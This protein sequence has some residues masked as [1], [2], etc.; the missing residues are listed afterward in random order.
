MNLWP[1]VL[2]LAPIGAAVVAFKRGAKLLAAVFGMVALLPLWAVL[3]V[4]GLP[5]LLVAVAGAALLGW[6]RWTRSS[7]TVTRWGARSRRKA[8]VASTLDVVRHARRAHQRD[9]LLE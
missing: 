4:I 8:G 5:L 3:S 1:I 6:H 7:A 2:V 9:G